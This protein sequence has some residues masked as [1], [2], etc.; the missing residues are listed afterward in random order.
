VAGKGARE[1][2]RRL[3]EEPEL[4]QT[5]DLTVLTGVALDKLAKWER[6]DGDG[7]DED[8]QKRLS[9]ML[10]RLSQFSGKVTLEVQRSDPVERAIDLTPTDPPRECDITRGRRSGI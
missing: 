9:Q 7:E 6:W 5:R 10:D 3:I 2:L 1:L 8:R 4:I